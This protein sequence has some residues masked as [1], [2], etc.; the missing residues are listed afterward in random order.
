MLT[1]AGTRRASQLL[2]QFPTCDVVHLGLH[3][4][5]HQHSL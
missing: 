2:L 3:G 5:W 4:C 1:E